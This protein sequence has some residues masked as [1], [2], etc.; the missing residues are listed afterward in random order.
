MAFNHYAEESRSTCT[1]QGGG[2]DL[3]GRET[4]LEREIEYVWNR[5]YFWHR[6]D[7]EQKNPGDLLRL[8]FSFV[9]APYDMAGTITLNTRPLGTQPDTGYTYVPAIRRIR[10]LGAADR[11]QSSLGTDG[12]TDD[13][14]G[15]CGRNHTMHWKF[16]KEQLALMNVCEWTTKNKTKMKETPRGWFTDN[17]V[18]DSLY[19][20]HEDKNWK[21]APWAPLNYVW[22][23]VR[24]YILEILAKDPY[25]AYGPCKYWV[26]KHSYNFFFKEMTNRAGEQWKL[27]V[28]PP[29]WTEWWGSDKT[30]Y[31]N[32]GVKIACSD[33]TNWLYIDGRLQHASMYSGFCYSKWPEGKL[34]PVVYIDPKM[35]ESY[36]TLRNLRSMA[37]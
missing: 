25:Y 17:S 33:M 35:P 11:S 13:S 7:G 26:E 18:I 6:A 36:F 2:I 21:G 10:K 12:V 32:P 37:K 23:P 24:A 29:F 28:T 31:P 9:E 22:V 14:N 20:G 8:Q 3:I 5:Y 1:I 30:Q 34:R 15:W 16:L 19:Y 4:G 27:G